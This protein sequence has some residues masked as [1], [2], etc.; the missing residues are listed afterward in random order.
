M[1][2]NKN[3]GLSVF[4]WLKGGKKYHKN[5]NFAKKYDLKLFKM[6]DPTED[7]VSQKAPLSVI[8]HPYLLKPWIKLHS[9][10]S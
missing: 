6:A 8:T 9:F 5:P 3:K 1:I 2:N 7:V 4:R 10:A